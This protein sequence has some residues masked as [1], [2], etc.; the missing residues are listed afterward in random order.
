MKL[1]CF[2][3]IYLPEEGD[4]S[5]ELSFLAYPGTLSGKCENALA[6]FCGFVKL[7]SMK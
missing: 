5:V 2:W 3:L 1:N 6:T 7:Q 4:H